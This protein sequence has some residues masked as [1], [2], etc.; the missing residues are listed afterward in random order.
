MD[1]GQSGAREAFD[2]AGRGC[3]D[4]QPGRI[5]EE[6]VIFVRKRRFDAVAG[7]FYETNAQI[8]HKIRKKF[9]FSIFSVEENRILK[10]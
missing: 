4:Q 9:V 3:C 2:R 1:G 6:L 8:S 10:K 5:A 7:G